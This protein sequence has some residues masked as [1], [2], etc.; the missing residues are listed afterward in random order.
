M[1]SV[2]GNAI[3]MAFVG[4]GLY[5]CWHILPRIKQNLVGKLE[6]NLEKKGLL[7]HYLI[8]HRVIKTFLYI[9]LA[10]MILLPALFF[11]MVVLD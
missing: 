3:K 9:V 6:N 5:V 11:L 4:A 2:W 10:L 1:E 8:L 7:K